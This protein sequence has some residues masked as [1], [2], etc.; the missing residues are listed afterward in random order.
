MTLI[1]IYVL[2]VYVFEI[3]MH[4]LDLEFKFLKGTNDL[5]SS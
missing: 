5:G 3:L 2:A 4:V 1:N